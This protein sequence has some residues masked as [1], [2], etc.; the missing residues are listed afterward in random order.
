[1][2]AIIV[3]GTAKEIASLVLALQERRELREPMIRI[4]SKPDTAE[5][6]KS[7]ADTIRDILVKQVAA[8]ST[9]RC[10]YMKLYQFDFIRELQEAADLVG[11]HFDPAERTEEELGQL[12]ELFCQDVRSYLAGTFTKYLK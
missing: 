12:Y 1:M 5:D 3:S 10:A 6:R 9:R 2:Q 11:I 4:A 7:L 8:G